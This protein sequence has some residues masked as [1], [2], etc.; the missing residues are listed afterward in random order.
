MSAVSP[1]ADD[2]PTSRDLRPATQTAPPMAG[3]AALS[4][5]ELTASSISTSSANSDCLDAHTHHTWL[6]ALGD[7]YL[8]GKQ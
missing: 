4:T 8:L 3:R 5:A 7:V 2:P 1:R 6:D